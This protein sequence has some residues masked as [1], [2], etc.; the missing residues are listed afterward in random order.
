M[1]ELH[2]IRCW[3]SSPIVHVIRL[4]QLETEIRIKELT[5]E[6]Q[7]STEYRKL[8]V[9]GKL[10][11]LLDPETGFAMHESS[12]IMI[13]LLQRFDRNLTLWFGNMGDD[14]N[15]Y[16]QAELLQW[17]VFGPASVYDVVDT[18]LSLTYRID[19]DHRDTKRISELI[20]TWTSKIE[21]KLLS[22]LQDGRPFLLDTYTAADI[23]LSF[24]LACAYYLHTFQN[25]GMNMDSR[26]VAYVQ[27]LLENPIAREL[28]SFDE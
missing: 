9:S 23:M 13:F 28:Y 3:A 11:I 1:L 2:H 16:R 15:I 4:L 7:R 27:R 21:P 8:N 25:C 19:P 24:P 12:A 6:I 10:P 14:S 5:K 22:S 17:I 20:R 18:L 26:I